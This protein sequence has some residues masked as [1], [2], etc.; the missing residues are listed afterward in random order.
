MRFP[1]TTLRLA[2]AGV[3]GAAAIAE[4][5]VG[6]IVVPAAGDTLVA[7]TTAEVKW[8]RLPADV[9]EMELFL[10]VDADGSKR[11]RLTPQLDSTLARYVWVVP[12]LPTPH[13]RLRLRVGRRGEETDGEPGDSFQIVG[14]ADLPAAPILFSA[15]EW[16]AGGRVSTPAEGE[17]PATGWTRRPQPDAARA[18]TPA[19]ANQEQLQP[20][21]ASHP[22]PNMPRSDR[23]RAAD[24]SLAAH[25]SNNMPL[26]E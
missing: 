2:L 17:R 21:A 10:F 20:V 12:N 23:R 24:A 13:A 26:R 8:D 3:L 5:G 25:R 1:L 11:I 9:D 15:G 18:A 6:R 19:P 14:R 22:N 7:G 4:A 16:W